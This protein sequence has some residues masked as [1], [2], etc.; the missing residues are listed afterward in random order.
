MS[1]QS[2]SNHRQIVFSYH[3]GLFGLIVATLIGASVN[4][5]RSW[6]DDSRSLTAALLVALTLAM[7]AS[8]FYMRI[9]ALKAQDR[10]IRAEEN[11]RHYVLT[12]SLLDSRLSIRQIVGL[13]FAQDKEFV[14]LAASAAEQGTSEG[15]IKKGIGDWR[16]DTYRV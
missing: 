5:Y 11:L 8:F 12:G 1:D 16:P 3:V 9:F 4:L 10:A 13:R 6:G 7:L 2:Y 14:E 15:D